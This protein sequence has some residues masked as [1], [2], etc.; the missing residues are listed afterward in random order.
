VKGEC[1]RGE[2]CPYRHDKPTDPDDPLSHQ[3]IRDRYYGTN[4]PVA[5]KMLN[6]LRAMPQM[7][8]P[9]DTSITTL[10]LSGLGVDHKVTESDIRDHFYQFGEMR[11]VSVIGDKGCAFVEFTT[12]AA[13]ELCVEKTFNNLN[14]WGRRIMVRWSQPKANNRDE[15]EKPLAPVP[16]LPDAL[17]VPDFF[18]L[19]GTKQEPLDLDPGT[20]SKRARRLPPAPTF[21][22]SSTGEVPYPEI[23]PSSGGGLLPNPPVIPPFSFTPYTPGGSHMPMAPVPPMMRQQPRASSSSAQ[24]HYDED[25]GASISGYGIHYPSQDPQRLGA[26]D[27]RD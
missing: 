10:F 16:G 11:R 1:K 2:E 22:S 24:Q 8:P 23:A 5:E 21:V 3:K 25:D 17:P 20:S 4:D 27:L 19:G 18:N 13:A 9:E 6:R 14:I 26:K 12:R 15:T 7:K